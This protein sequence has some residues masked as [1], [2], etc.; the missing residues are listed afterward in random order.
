[1]RLEVFPRHSASQNRGEGGVRRSGER[2]PNAIIQNREV[3][4]EN[5][6][7][8]KLNIWEIKT[9]PFQHLNR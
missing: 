7:S 8:P 4:R 1:M 2:T 3:S 5:Y 6:V 9:E